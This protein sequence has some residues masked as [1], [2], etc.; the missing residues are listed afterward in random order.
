MRNFIKVADYIEFGFPFSIGTYIVLPE[1]ILNNNNKLL[2]DRDRLTTILLHEQIHI[3]QRSHGRMYRQFFSDLGFVPCD[4]LT[5]PASLAAFLINN[6][7]DNGEQWVYKHDTDDYYY[8]P[9]MFLDATWKPRSRVFLAI[10]TDDGCV[11]GGDGSH[12]QVLPYEV[13]T[14]LLTPTETHAY[15]VAQG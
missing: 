2:K 11:G 5:L 15:Q 14:R 7:D 3:H 8:W 9:A 1:R 4:T 6:P 13:E 10:R 12:F